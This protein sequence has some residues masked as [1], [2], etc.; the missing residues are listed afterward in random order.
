MCDP[1]TQY[2]L[3]LTRAKKISPFFPLFLKKLRALSSLSLQ[4]FDAQ[5]REMAEKTTKNS[6]RTKRN[7]QF[8]VRPFYGVVQAIISRLITNFLLSTKKKQFSYD[9][10]HRHSKIHYGICLY[11]ANVNW[12]LVFFSSFRLFTSSL[13]IRCDSLCV[14]F[15]PTQTTFNQYTIFSVLAPSLLP[16]VCSVWRRY[17]H[18]YMYLHVSIYHTQKIHRRY[19]G[20]SANDSLSHQQLH[21]D[22]QRFRQNK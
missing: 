14:S 1:K 12:V 9:D 2:T 13:R 15:L 20:P 4:L 19:V 10:I 22:C 21:F 7:A 8:N 5:F 18:I 11:S 3:L 17:T 16:L 6:T